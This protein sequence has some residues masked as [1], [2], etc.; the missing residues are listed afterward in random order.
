[1]Y[2]LDISAY[3]LVVK[4]I[5]DFENVSIVQLHDISF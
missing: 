3:E 5:K 4:R 1:M 2:Q